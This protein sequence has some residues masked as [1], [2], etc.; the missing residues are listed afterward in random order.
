M[1]N[2]IAT[3]LQSQEVLSGLLDLYVLEFG[4]NNSSTLYFH[5]G[6]GS[7][8]SEITFRDSKAPYTTRTYVALPLELKGIEVTGDGAPA[9]PVLTVANVLTEFRTDLGDISAD[10]IVGARL[11]RRRTLEKYLS[12]GSNSSAPTEFPEESYVIDRIAEENSLYIKYELTNPFD[13]N[14]IQ[15]PRRVVVGK[16]C[17]WVYRGLEPDYTPSHKLCGACDWEPVKTNGARSYFTEYNQPL[18]LRTTANAWLSGT[19]YSA[20]NFV[21]LNNFIYRSDRVS[22]GQSPEN[23]GSAYWQRVFFYDVWTSLSNSVQIDV[24]DYVEH[25]RTVWKCIRQHD[26][27]ASKTPNLTSSYWTI[28]DSCQKTLEAC[29]IRFGSN[30][31]NNRLTGNVSTRNLPFGAF[32][33]SD[34]F[35]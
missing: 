26:K 27:S 13:L 9:R 32:P 24:G 18:I 6:L 21:T 20:Q 17:S 15:L 16:Y 23:V 2:I 1:T 5:P 29:R 34:K 25:E 10:D 3:D 19:T 11:T 8:L 31:Q 33:G 4:D 14:N 35:K 30:H 7:N 22:T 12:S 28:A